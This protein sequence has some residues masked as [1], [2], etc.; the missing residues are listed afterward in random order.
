MKQE[1]I[2]LTSLLVL[3]FISLSGCYLDPK[4]RYPGPE[5]PKKDLALIIQTDNLEY[6]P[7]YMLASGNGDGEE[8]RVD[9]LGITVLPGTYLFKAKLYHSQLRQTR[10]IATLPVD[11]GKSDFPVEQSSLRWARADEPYKETGE[12][13][14]AFKAGFTYGLW[15]SDEEKIEMKILGPY[16]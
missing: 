2:L 13:E 9:D 4:K 8:I 12:V 6:C 14:L 7:I 16:K 3:F 11:P 10:R 1:S 15:C 5:R